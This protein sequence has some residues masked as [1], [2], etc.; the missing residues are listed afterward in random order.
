MLGEGLFVDLPGVEVVEFELE[1]ND[2]VEVVCMY[3]WMGDDW[4]DVMLSFCVIC[5]SL[6]L[7]CTLYGGS[8][9]C[10]SV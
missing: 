1:L 4:N 9:Y 8:G 3:V 5:G 6:R 2:I 7:L 10:C